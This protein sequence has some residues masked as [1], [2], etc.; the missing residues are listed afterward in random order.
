[1]DGVSDLALWDY[2]QINSNRSSSMIRPRSL[3]IHITTFLLTIIVLIEPISFKPSPTNAKAQQEPNERNAAEN[4]KSQ[5]LAFAFE[6]SSSR[7]ERTANERP[8]SPTT[9]R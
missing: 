3:L 6:L 9:S 8:N 4:A 7:E 1:M 2:I 5:Q